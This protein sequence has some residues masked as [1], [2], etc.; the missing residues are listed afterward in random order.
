MP[1]PTPFLNRHRFWGAALMMLLCLLAVG[2]SALG[3]RLDSFTIDEPWHVVAGTHYV[4]TGDFHLNPEQPPLVKL[5]VGAFM[6]RAFKLPPVPVLKEKA[7]EREFTETTMY[8]GNDSEAVQARAR[9]AMWSFHG[10]LLFVLGLLCW[11]AFG[12]AWA[13]GTLGFLAIEPSIGAHLPVVMMD[14]ALGL[15]LPITALCAGL[16]FATW[17]W[18]WA[19]ALGVAL[20]L[21]LGAKHSALA[22]LLG[23]GLLCVLMALRALPVDMPSRLTRMAQIGFAGVLG[24]ALLWAQYGFHFHA[25]SDGSDPF[26]MAMADKIAGL[27]V[28]RLRQAIEIA[29]AAQLLPRSY[30]WGLA[31]TVRAGVEGRGQSEHLV[32]GHIYSGSPPWFTWPSIVVSKLPLG[33]MAMSLLGLLAL[34]R[35]RPEPSTRPALLAIAVMSFAHLAALMSSQGTYAGVRHALP[36]VVALAILAGAAVALAW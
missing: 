2:R 11:R 16:L 9:L 4:R 31:D 15:T 23:L 8:Q 22:G 32:W 30:L 17:R 19:A 24:L 20:A 6:G 34:W 28:P 5:W 21:C 13:A 12:L 3:T 33:L 35:L 1:E 25:R 27:Q 18:R 26:N 14:L 36:L 29:D 10:L 7:N